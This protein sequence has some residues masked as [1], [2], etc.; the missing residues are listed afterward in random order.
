M[1]TC[2]ASINEGSLFQSG[3]NMLHTFSGNRENI[4][5]KS[6]KKFENM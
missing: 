4:G 2:D 3:K 1:N 6:K 5:R